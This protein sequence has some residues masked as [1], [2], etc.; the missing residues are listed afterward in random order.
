MDQ[1]VRDVPDIYDL[2]GIAQGY[3]ADEIAALLDEL[4]IEN[5]M[6]NQRGVSHA[7]IQ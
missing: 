4:G 6:I 2:S 5:Y 3:A 7:R 1:F